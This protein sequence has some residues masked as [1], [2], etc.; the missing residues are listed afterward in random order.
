MENYNRLILFYTYFYQKVFSNPN[1]EYNPVAKHI[2][3]IWSF[4]MYLEENISLGDEWLFKY[5]AFQF[6]YWA[7]K[8]EKKIKTVVSSYIFGEKAQIRFKERNE[9]SDYFIEE[10]IRNYKLNIDDLT[11]NK[12]YKKDLINIT[13]TEEDEKLR[14]VDGYK[15][16]VNCIEHT[17]LF[18]IKSP[19]C[20]FHCSKSK[21]CREIQQDKYPVIYKIRNEKNIEKVSG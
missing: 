16:I 7:S 13:K 11:K 1:F 17:T 21:I 5:M 2:P 3:P 18:N 9:E 20:V 10:F 15:R 14:F 8:K 12:Y 4:A 6:E 19:I